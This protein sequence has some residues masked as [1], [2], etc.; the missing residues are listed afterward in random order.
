MK[1]I[2]YSGIYIAKIEREIRRI[3]LQAEV[4]GWKS[5]TDVYL[6]YAKTSQSSGFLQEK[7]TFLGIIENFEKFGL[8]LGR[9]RQHKILRK[10]SYDALSKE[11][12]SLIDYYCQSEK[13]RGKK[14]STIHITSHNA[15]SFLLALQK[16][17]MDT[18]EKIT[19]KAVLEIFTDQNGN[20]N[21][22]YSYKQSIS[23][24]LKAGE[25]F[26]SQNI[27]ARVLSYLPA[28]RRRRKN[29]QYLTSKEISQIKSVLTEN[30][31]ETL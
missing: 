11:F 12:K 30:K 22:C 3:I 28:L 15:T 19:E 9:R 29:I 31:N 1:K 26:L 20:P 5:Y 6:E 4:K 25:S 13:T 23:I 16:K 10:T 7:R 27:C 14:E 2:G 24:V 18:L 21:K 8:N 17:G